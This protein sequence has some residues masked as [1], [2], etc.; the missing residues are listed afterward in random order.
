MA[1]QEQLK[2]REA[3]FGALALQVQSTMDQQATI[4]KL[5][6]ENSMLQQQ[7][8][9]T[10]NSQTAQDIQFDDDDEE[11]VIIER[12]QDRPSGPALSLHQLD[13]IQQSSTQLPNLRV[14]RDGGPL[15]LYIPLERKNGVEATKILNKIWESIAA[16]ESLSHE[17]WCLTIGGKKFVDRSATRSL[18]MMRKLRTKEFVIQRQKIGTSSQST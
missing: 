8:A 3:E 2:Q 10:F 15:D 18:M 11:D 9:A 5:R 14:E 12:A 13:G 7:L 4:N 6:D 17:K 1:L 16:Q